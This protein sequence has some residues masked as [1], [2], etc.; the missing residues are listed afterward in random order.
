MLTPWIAY[1]KM[2]PLSVAPCI[3][4]CRSLAGTVQ[5]SSD[6]DFQEQA[7]ALAGCGLG[8]LQA[9]IQAGA[10]VSSRLSKHCCCCTLL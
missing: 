8:H 9:G 6:D 1:L 4:F 5:S 3:T 2:Y 7:C 10:I